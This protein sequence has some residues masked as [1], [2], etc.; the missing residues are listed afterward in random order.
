MAEQHPPAGLPAVKLSRQALVADYGETILDALPRG[1]EPVFAEEG[2]VPPD[3]VA[4][5]F[6]FA[7][8]DD[9]VRAMVAAP[10]R[11]DAIRAAADAEM[12]RR[13]GDMLRD[14][15]AAEAALDAVHNDE[16]ADLL[17]A[18][19]EALRR[20]V[21]NAGPS[22]TSEAAADRAHQS[23]VRSRVGQAAKPNR[24]LAAKQRSASAARDALAADDPAEA[25]RQ[26]TRQFMAFHFWREARRI[27]Q[28]VAAAIA[29]I[30]TFGRRE[31]RDPLTGDPMEQID[32]L[33]DRFGLR[34]GPRRPVRPRRSLAEF[35]TDRFAAG[36]A[37][38][39]EPW[40]LQGTQRQDYAA[41]TVDAFRGLVDAVRNIEHLGR[42]DHKLIVADGERDR[43]AVI[44]EVAGSIAANALPGV[45]TGGH[46]SAPASVL[47][48]L[49]NPDA[50][51]RRLDRGRAD[52]PAFRHLKG[53]V[54]AALAERWL[55]MHR[56]AGEDLA[57]LF[58]VYSPAE[59]QRMHRP[60]RVAGVRFPLSHWSA[61]AL[62]LN[63]GSEANRQ[64]V[65]AG[66][67]LNEVEIAALLTLLDKRDWDFVQ[68]VW[69]HI[70]GF[71]PQVAAAHRRRSGT[72][73]IKVEPATVTTRFGAYRGGAYPLAFER[74]RSLLAVSDVA[75]A[76]RRVA[77]GRF[78]YAQT[79]RGFGG[80]STMGVLVAA[81]SPGPLSRQTDD[82]QNQGGVVPAQQATAVAGP[83][84]SFDIG[85]LHRHLNQLVYD[86]AMGDAVSYALAVLQSPTVGRALADTGH[87]G[88]LTVLETWLRDATAGDLVIG[89]A[90]A[91]AADRRRTDY[92]ASVPARA[93]GSALIR[94]AGIE[95]LIRRLGVS[96]AAQGVRALVTRPLAGPRSAFAEAQ[97][98]SDVLRR[99]TGTAG[100]SISNVTAWA[101]DE[102]I[103]V[104]IRQSHDYLAAKTRLMIDTA[105]WLGAYRKG[106]DQSDGDEGAAVAFADRMVSENSVE[107]D[108]PST[109]VQPWTALL[110]Y[111]LAKSDAAI[112]GIRDAGLVSPLQIVVGTL[113]LAMVF[114][115]DALAAAVIGA[116]LPAA[117][118]TTSDSDAPRAA[119]EILAGLSSTIEA[120]G[121]ETV[122]AAYV[123]S[124]F[125]E[126]LGRLLDRFVDETELM[127]A[128]AVGLDAPD[129]I[130]IHYP[131]AQGRALVDT[132]WRIPDGVAL[133]MSRLASAVR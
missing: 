92:A 34:R 67:T 132:L 131:S 118:D 5:W 64:A 47:G 103:H 101:V 112:D 25:L 110:N 36:Q 45:D 14:G 8:G 59:R 1:G 46:L 104:E 130:L 86:L 61:I 124:P 71:W 109:A 52:G 114:A 77:A 128:I 73:P 28:E 108:E 83:P 74:G 49:A 72:D 133:P 20:R 90:L 51:L 63:W 129:S 27:E 91:R 18:E 62:A 10:Q 99:R 48:A 94:D 11:E 102:S 54:D 111:M 4:G 84:V 88:A 43:D 116:R 44:S 79:L 125:A 57:K 89:D 35:A 32:A 50:V 117:D 100:R 56:Q 24:F 121:N 9:M 6:G 13:H 39:I 127:D 37:V 68:S 22:P 23:L 76:A 16:H 33:I 19:M 105:V 95:R 26:K 120:G 75:G 81:D 15:R 78:V 106:L 58:A 126:P 65:R 30:G 2:G 40:L 70:D 42:L 96:Y 31:V 7:S 82:G 80:R 69:D 115:L 21:P 98:L 55:P 107:V 41:L 53:V 93:V 123:M 122:G 17:A 29:Y 97:R 38:D 3:Q 12:L 87:G 85:A 66:G 113:D 60:S 119:N